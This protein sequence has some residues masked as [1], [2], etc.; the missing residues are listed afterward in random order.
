MDAL[1]VMGKKDK[2]FPYFQP[3]VSAD[4]QQIIGYEVLGRIRTEEGIKSLGFFFEDSSIPEEYILEIDTHIRNAAIDYF[5]KRES[6]QSLFLNCNAR[7][8]LYDH[9][10]TITNSLED[11]ATSGI[12]YGKIVI[13]VSGYDVEDD[14][15]QKLQHILTYYKSLGVQVAISHA[16]STMSN[17][18]KI[19][20]LNPNIIKVDLT[21]LKDKGMPPEYREVLY[22]LSMLGRKIGATLLFEGIEGIGQ[23]KYAWE[24]GGR[25]YQGYY[26]GRPGPEFLSVDK[27]K[28]LL[29]K[30]FHHFIEHER[31]RLLSLYTLSQ[32]FNHH[33][34]QQVKRTKHNDW[35]VIVSEAAQSLGEACF[36]G[37]ICDE[38]GR[39]VSANYYRNGEGIW[40]S[41]PEYEGD[42]WSWRPYFLENIVRMRHEQ[43]G[44][45]SD[46][47]SDIET[48]EL[49]RTYSY[50]INETHYL[51]L[52]IP[53]LY[54]YERDDY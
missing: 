22:A 23:L 19:A 35:N 8:L 21:N 29:T 42:N 33:L 45:L 48:N 12:S 11:Y 47:Y 44:I 15:L 24:N 18:E 30:E 43:V 3:I 31:K 2:I 1:D 10:E 32:N 52:D 26:L 20:F 41:Q 50:P 36:R 51:F 5:Q 14:Q 28:P 13:E 7:H 4:K 53:Y 25:Y 40:E 38:D 46:L 27:C 34:Q 37:Y 17:I 39:Q 54:L 16:G 9:G 49:I 6:D